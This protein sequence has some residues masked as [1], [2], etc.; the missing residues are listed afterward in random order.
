MTRRITD[1]E[2]EQAAIDSALN[3]GPAQDMFH[4]DFGWIIR[5]GIITEVGEKFFKYIR[6]IEDY[7]K[8]TKN[9]P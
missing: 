4:P 7:D 2:I 5:N 6:E 8:I 3:M 1:E 9:N